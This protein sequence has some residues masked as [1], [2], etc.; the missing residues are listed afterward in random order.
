METTEIEDNDELDAPEPPPPPKRKGL[1]QAF[2]KPQIRILSVMGIIALAVVVI[3]I[4]I[5]HSHRKKTMADIPSAIPK[6]AVAQ[7]VHKIGE[8]TTPEYQKKMKEFNSEQEKAAERQHQTYMPIPTGTF[9]KNSGTIPQGQINVP[10]IGVPY[11]TQVAIAREKQRE[12]IEINR[13]KNYRKYTDMMLKYWN[14]ENQMPLVSDIPSIPHAPKGGKAGG[15]AVLASANSGLPSRTVSAK[16]NLGPVII[17]RTD[18]YY[19]VALNK[20]N[21]D[22]PGEFLVQLTNGPLSGATI[23]GGIKRVNT[24]MTVSF[25]TAKWKDSAGDTHTIPIDAVAIDA[26]T[27]ETAIRTSVNHHYFERY[28]L[29]AAAGFLQGVGE[30]YMMN[31]NTTVSGMGVMSVNQNTANGSAMMGLGQMGQ[32]LAGDFQNNMNIPPTVKFKDGDPV[33][34][35]FLKDVHS[36]VNPVAKADVLNPDQS[37]RSAQMQ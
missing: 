11:E 31:G 3:V 30:A 35:L 23:M 12:A 16:Q 18:V 25:D 13:M 10:Q 21:T 26:K 24:F 7:G 33:G 37:T 9:V 14:G 19:G 5:V 28:A 8:K 22:H 15:K 29:V 36:P 17:H 1:R 2:E 6:P 20:G 32:T 34:V 27:G 4:V